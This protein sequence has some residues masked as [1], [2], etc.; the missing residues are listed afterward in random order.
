MRAFEDSE[1]LRH[2]AEKNSA[3]TP[4]DDIEIINTELILADIQTIEKRLRDW[5][6]KRELIRN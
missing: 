4:Q 5:K 2:D 3:P 6:K 1:I